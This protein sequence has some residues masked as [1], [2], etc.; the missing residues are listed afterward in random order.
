[1]AAG[2]AGAMALL[3]SPDHLRWWGNTAGQLGLLFW[4]IL[5]GVI[6]VYAS[7]GNAYRRLATSSPDGGFLTALQSM[8]G[9][10]ATALAIASRLLLTAGLSTGVLVTAGFVF[11]ETFV[12][13][14]PNFGF[15]FIC[16]VAAALTTLWGY[17][18]ATRIQSSLAVLAIL[19]LAALVVPGIIAW[20][21]PPVAEPGEVHRV[22]IHECAG[23]LLL[24]AGFDVTIHHAAPTR[25]TPIDTKRLTAVLATAGVLLGL[26]GTVSLAHV[27]AQRLETSFI[28]YTLAA[29]AIADQTGRI[30]IGIALIT[31]S[32]AAVT[33]LF[34]ATCRII[35]TVSQ[36]GM[37]PGAAGGSDRRNTAVALLLTGAVAAMLTLGFAGST[38]LETFIRAGFLLWLIH[39]ILV[40]ALAWCID[41]QRPTGRAWL[42]ALSAGVLGAGGVILWVQDAQ[43]TRLSLYVVASWAPL[44]IILAVYRRFYPKPVSATPANLENGEMPT[45]T[46]N[47]PTEAHHDDT[48]P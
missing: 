5:I 28:P 24:F 6:A 35:G 38:E 44:F 19:S 29:R 47:M 15:A 10:P 18:A 25:E 31:G 14:F 1:M 13:W 33:A 22:S 37:L 41:A 34:S 43:R 8:G 7:S 20:P 26:W 39:L 46:T 16:L 4:P 27:P 30:L 36:M 23:A 11:N 21:G 42:T 40:H 2:V 9:A 12:H 3:L 45:S 32:V 48:H 17:Q